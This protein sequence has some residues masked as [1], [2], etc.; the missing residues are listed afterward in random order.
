MATSASSGHRPTSNLRHALAHSSLE[1]IPQSPHTPVR[2]T[3]PQTLPSFSPSTRSEDDCIIFEFGTRYMRAGYAN[4][5]EPRCVIGF[6]PD[7]QGRAGDYSQWEPQ[8]QNDRRSRR[9]SLPWGEAH[10]LWRMDLRNVDLGHVEDKLERAVRE[11]Y[12]K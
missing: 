9:G 10:E 6:G 8:R 5:H 7:E 3:T 11:S 4:D 12:T 1:G 2:Q